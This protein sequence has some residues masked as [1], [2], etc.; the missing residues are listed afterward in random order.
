M[1]VSERKLQ[2]SHMSQGGEATLDQEL[3]GF[4]MDIGRGNLHHILSYILLELADNAGKANLK[5]AYFLESGL[6]IFKKSDYEKGMRDFKRQV[7]SHREHYLKRLKREG[8]QVWVHLF[9][10]QDH[11]IISVRNN[12][13]ITPYERVNMDDRFRKAERFHTVEEVSSRGLDSSEGGGF[14]LVLMLLL[15]QSIGLDHRVFT[16]DAGPD[17]TEVRVSIPYNLISLQEGEVIADAIMDE[18]KAIP[19]FPPHILELEKMLRDPASDFVT[20]A[21][22]IRQ[23][24]SL[25]ADL[26]KTVNS[27]LYAFSGA[28]SSIEEA[29]KLVGF[30]GVEQLVLFHTSK[31]ILK[32]RYNL[33]NHQEIMEHDMQV[34]RYA[35]LIVDYLKLKNVEKEEVYVAAL[36]HDIGKIVVNA[37]RPGMLRKVMQICSRKGLQS[38]LLENLSNGYNHTIIGARLAEKWRFPE[39]LVQAIRYHHTPLQA[40]ERFQDLLIPIYLGNMLYYCNR[41]NYRFKDLNYRILERVHLTREADF[42]RMCEHVVKHAG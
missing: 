34:A 17:Y 11:C 3:Y 23:D 10:E 20:L 21:K 38:T 27:P 15:L 42:R 1:T 12:T 41:G 19:Q 22:I 9:V 16:L 36:L 4:L 37:L 13:P 32:Q 39:Q 40:E 33:A 26:L 8:L 29:V 30:Q 31:S 35:A 25:T 14:G 6:D 5:R 28:I 18:I 2:F 7:S 24:A